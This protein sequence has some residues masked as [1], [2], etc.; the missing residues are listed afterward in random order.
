MNINTGILRIGFRTLTFNGTEKFISSAGFS[1]G[2]VD[3]WVVAGNPA[4]DAHLAA[5][6]IEHR[7]E[8][9]SANRDFYSFPGVCAPPPLRPLGAIK[10]EG[11]DSNGVNGQNCRLLRVSQEKFLKYGHAR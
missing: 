1:G 11:Q 10:R 3:S 6:A 7:A 5:I 4:S 8:P 2:W 9:V